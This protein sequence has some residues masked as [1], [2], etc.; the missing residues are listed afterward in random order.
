MTDIGRLTEGQ[1]VS[2]AELLELLKAPDV[3]L[4]RFV[5]THSGEGRVELLVGNDRRVTVMVADP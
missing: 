2:T 5:S 1:P 3:E 4:G